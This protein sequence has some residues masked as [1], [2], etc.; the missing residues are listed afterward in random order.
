MR[1]PA[2]Q[3]GTQ[4]VPSGGYEADRPLPVAA[5]ACAQARRE[6]GF[7]CGHLQTFPMAGARTGGGRWAGM[8]W[9]RKPGWIPQA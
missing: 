6:A 1:V 7:C 8:G 4:Q 5:T 3:E 2:A 9:S